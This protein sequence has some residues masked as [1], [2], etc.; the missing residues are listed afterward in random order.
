MKKETIDETDIAKKIA[1]MIEIDMKEYGIGY[2]CAKGRV[3]AMIED[4]MRH[5]DEK[6]S[7]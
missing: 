5:L 4:K 1:A 7:L 3:F 6:E 2:E